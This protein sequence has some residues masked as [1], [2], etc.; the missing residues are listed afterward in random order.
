[1]AE[2]IKKGK[3]GKSFNGVSDLAGCHG[4]AH[5]LR[6]EITVY[7]SGI[8]APVNKNRLKEGKLKVK[9]SDGKKRMLGR[10]AHQ[11]TTINEQGTNEPTPAGQ[12][13]KGTHHPWGKIKIKVASWKTQNKLPT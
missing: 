13:E 7:E 12:S 10:T 4:S 5:D 9:A 6:G 3:Q 2:R 8:E 1:L 11:K